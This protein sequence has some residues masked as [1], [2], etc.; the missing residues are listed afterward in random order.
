MD[1]YNWTMENGVLG[2]ATGEG[3]DFKPAQFIP[4]ET[5]RTNWIEY[6]KLEIDDGPVG[7]LLRNHIG[8]TAPSEMGIT[9]VPAATYLFPKEVCG[10]PTF[11]PQ[12]EFRIERRSTAEC[13]PPRRWKTLVEWAQHESF[14]LKL[15]NEAYQGPCAIK[16]LRFEA[17]PTEL[18]LV[19]STA[20]HYHLGGK[21]F[22]RD[23]EE[24]VI[25]IHE[26]SVRVVEAALL[27]APAPYGSGFADE[28]K[29]YQWC[30]EAHR[31]LRQ[32]MRRLLRELLQR[33]ESSISDQ[34]LLREVVRWLGSSEPADTVPQF[35][36]SL[37]FA[38]R[39]LYEREPFPSMRESN[40][41]MD[42]QLRDVVHDFLIFESSL[43]R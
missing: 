27:P 24:V 4:A 41:P 11:S 42:E 40:G 7:T 8:G 38:L 26:R 39:E 18:E 5:P 23:T 1:V 32:Q 9:A 31:E 36:L 3:N 15:C 33:V 22:R 43:M 35:L 28:L 37:V 17:M 13:L 30:A 6:L 34:R 12:L 19:I 10:E 2:T 25:G 14:L 16:E 21:V 20:R 29:T